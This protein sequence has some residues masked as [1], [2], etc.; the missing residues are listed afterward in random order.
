MTPGFS[1]LNVRAQMAPPLQVS[2]WLKCPVLLDVHEMESL[3]SEL[4]HFWIFLTGGVVPQDGGQ[5][6]KSE[7]LG[8]YEDYVEALKG[9]SLPDEAIMR[10]FFS[11]VWTIDPEMVYGV[12]M[13]DGRQII[14]VEKPVVQLQPHRFDYSLV[15]GKFRSMVFGSDTILWGI[16]F[17]YP[18]LYQN[19][20]LEV[21]Q[22]RETAEFPNTA[23]FRSLQ[24]WIRQNTV[25]TPFLVGEQRTNVPIRLGKGCFDWINQH[26]QLAAKNLRVAITYSQ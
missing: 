2:K 11:S 17:S 16:Q 13:G 21:K 10:S 12:K 23:F 20:K 19:I 8:R 7:F 3:L 9:G 15:D 22:V 24:R 1:P 14:G 26:P 5:I 4:G 18:Q 25:A 6:S